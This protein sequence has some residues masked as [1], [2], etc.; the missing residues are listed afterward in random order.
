MRES[1]NKRIVNNFKSPNKSVNLCDTV[2]AAS[3]IRE[4]LLL[5]AGF[6]GKFHL[7]KFKVC[8]RQLHE[9]FYFNQPNI[10]RELTSQ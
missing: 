8:Q 2:W 6:Y 3:L 5:I 1:D 4:G 9:K 7:D 10:Y